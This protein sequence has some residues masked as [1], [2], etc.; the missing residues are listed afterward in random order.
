[1][2]QKVQ[3]ARGMLA[4][5]KAEYERRLRSVE[6]LL[7]GAVAEDPANIDACEDVRRDYATLDVEMRLFAMALCPEPQHNDPQPRPQE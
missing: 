2:S 7:R 3:D 6:S 4:L 1:M 5:A